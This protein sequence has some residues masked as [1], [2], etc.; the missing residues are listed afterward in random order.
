MSH[1][2]GCPHLWQGSSKV[3]SCQTFCSSLFWSMDLFFAP[4]PAPHSTPYPV[5]PRVGFALLNNRDTDS[6]KAIPAL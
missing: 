6:P 1:L 3:L 2:V 4:L 5:P